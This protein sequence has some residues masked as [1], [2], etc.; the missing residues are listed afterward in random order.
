MK[1]KIQFHLIFLQEYSIRSAA[2]II[3]I[4]N[5]NL[6]QGIYLVN[7]SLLHF[8]V[9]HCTYPVARGL[10]GEHVEE[11]GLLAEGVEPVAKPCG[12]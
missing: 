11:A 3:N 9:V 7:E 2:F 8:G 1:A 10:L 12:F 4:S 5:L 6:F